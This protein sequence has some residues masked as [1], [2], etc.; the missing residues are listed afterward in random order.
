MICKKE[1]ERRGIRRR[2]EIKR[3]KGLKRRR[4][5]KETLPWVTYIMNLSLIKRV[6]YWKLIQFFFRANL[7]REIHPGCD[8]KNRREKILISL[9]LLAATK[10]AASKNKSKIQGI[11]G[12]RYHSSPN[13]VF[14]EYQIR[15][16]PRFE[17]CRGKNKYQVC[18]YEWSHKRS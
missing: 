5:E 13:G 6:E 11:H 7:T 12:R 15:E 14:V 10:S 17:F 3:G 18:S 1:K 9:R 8:E 2:G 16:R 4:R